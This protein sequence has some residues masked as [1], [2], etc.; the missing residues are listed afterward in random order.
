MITFEEY[1]NMAR[2][3]HDL[4][5]DHIPKNQYDIVNRNNEIIKKLMAKYNLSIDI[6][7]EIFTNNNDSAGLKEAYEKRFGSV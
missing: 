3:A 4:C 7:T 1:K 6:A 5:K 2:Y